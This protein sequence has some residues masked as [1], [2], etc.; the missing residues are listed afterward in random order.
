MPF[1]NNNMYLLIDKLASHL[2]DM[3]R[4]ITISFLRQVYVDND[5]SIV[6]P[7]WH[8]K[9]QKNNADKSYH[10]LL[11]HEKNNFHIEA[12]K[13]LKVID[14]LGLLNNLVCGDLDKMIEEEKNASIY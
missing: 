2:F 11:P 10:D 6:M 9:Q 12:L 14:E 8:F 3:T 7:K 5:N 13:I 4:K 1:N